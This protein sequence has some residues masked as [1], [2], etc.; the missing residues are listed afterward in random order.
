MHYLEPECKIVTPFYIGNLKFSELIRIVDNGRIAYRISAVKHGRIIDAPGRG[1]NN[2]H[3]L[4]ALI[5]FFICSVSKAIAVS[6]HKFQLLLKLVR[7]PNIVT[8]KK[9]NIVAVCHIHSSVACRGGTEVSVGFK[10][11]YSVVVL[12]HNAHYV[13]RTVRGFV[14]GNDKLPVTVGL[15]LH[16]SYALD[17]VIRTV[18]RRHYY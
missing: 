18:I 12:C 17:Y 1:N 4:A 11:T 14:I 5:Y 6:L 2:T 10:Q 13:N 15:T 8:V 3:V 7:I 16:G 9:R